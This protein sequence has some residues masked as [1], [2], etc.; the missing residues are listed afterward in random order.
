M[1]VISI[2]ILLLEKY[3]AGAK[4]CL[5]Q[6]QDEFVILADKLSTPCD[7]RCILLARLEITVRKIIEQQAWE[8][9]CF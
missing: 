6:Y 1:K 8:S 4:L 2:M 5:G 7:D 3:H 9:N